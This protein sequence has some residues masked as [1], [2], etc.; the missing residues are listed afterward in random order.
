MAE[1]AKT[2]VDYFETMPIPLEVE[3]EA[4]IGQGELDEQHLSIGSKVA[5]HIVKVIKTGLEP[6]LQIDRYKLD[7]EI[8]TQP[9]LVH[10]SSLCVASARRWADHYNQLL[11]A[12]VPAV[13]TNLRLVIYKD[14]K[15]T[16]ARLMQEAESDFRVARVRDMKANWDTMYRRSEAAH[17]AIVQKGYSLNLLVELWKGEY[18]AA[19]SK[20]AKKK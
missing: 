16:E 20:M 14:E 15:I 5:T 11:K 12:V 3:Q 13:A 19:D 1:K 2:K 4:L 6:N 9:E 18:F 8:E 7:R 17:E 10:L